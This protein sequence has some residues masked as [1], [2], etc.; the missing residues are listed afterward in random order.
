MIFLHETHEIVGGKAREFEDAYREIYLPLVQTGER[1]RLV[2]YW[3]HTHGTGPSYQAI[4]MT[5][6]RDW[7]TW[8]EIV[9]EMKS[10]PGW[11]RWWD[12][13][14]EV[15]REVRTKLMQATPWSPLQEVDLSGGGDPPAHDP[16]LYLHD[17]GWPYVGKLDAYVDAL[18]S[19]FYP[20]TAKYKMISVAACWTTCPGSGRHH[21]VLLLQKIENWKLFSHLLTAGERPV[22]PG[23][24]MVEGLRFRDQWESKLLRTTEWSPTY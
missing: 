19:I 22:Q 16:T 18:G 3:H 4:S 21:E 9:A 8:G 1:A 7:Q 20:A 15:R 5:A 2:W 17:T 11:R 6:I 12:A 10:D 23:D 14:W 24:W 13:C